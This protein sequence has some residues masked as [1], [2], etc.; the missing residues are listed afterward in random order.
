MV[1]VRRGR[2]LPLR[3][4]SL[5]STRPLLLSLEL[6]EL[7]RPLVSYPRLCRGVC[8]GESEL[9]PGGFLEEAWPWLAA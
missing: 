7:R 1:A 8:T 9:A 3:S 5:V 2:G 4:R 6:S